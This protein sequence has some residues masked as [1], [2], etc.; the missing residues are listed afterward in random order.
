MLLTNNQHEKNKYIG[1]H[2]VTT[3]K[4]QSLSNFLPKE[5]KQQTKIHPET[6]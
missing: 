6:I 1:A 2:N 4:S 5:S 3:H